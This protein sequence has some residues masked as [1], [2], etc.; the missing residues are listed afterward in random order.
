MDRPEVTSPTIAVRPAG[1]SAVIDLNERRI[2]RD[3]KAYTFEQFA[4]YYGVAYA[5][6]IWRGT[7]CLD[8]AEQPVDVIADR[9]QDTVEEPDSIDCLTTPE[10]QHSRLSR[11]ELAAAEQPVDITA[12]HPEDSDEQP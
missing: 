8:S 5:L 9:P 3:G 11:D 10:G 6:T 1:E 2:A 12:G 4:L 7:E